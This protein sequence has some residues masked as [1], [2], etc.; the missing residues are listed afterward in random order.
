MIPCN[1]VTDPVLISYV[2]FCRIIAELQKLQD[3]RNKIADENQKYIDA[4]PE[5]RMLIDEFVSAAIQAKPNDLVK[6]GSF[7]FTHWK[8]H[9]SVGPCPVVIAG[10][11]GAGKTTLINKLMKKFPNLCGFSISHTTRNPRQGEENGVHFNF[12][13]KEEFEEMIEKRQFVEHT[14]LHMNYYGTS[15][16]SIEKVRAIGMDE[17]LC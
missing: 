5:M 3:Y 16:Q 7:F 8:K 14:K 2:V 13:T 17:V 9:G 11:S 15:I 1:N 12:V 6:F 4:H 10:P